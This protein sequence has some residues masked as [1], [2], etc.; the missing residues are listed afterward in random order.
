MCGWIPGKRQNMAVWVFLNSNL[1]E[2]PPWSPRGVVEDAIGIEPLDAF[3]HRSHTT[4][5]AAVSLPRLGKSCAVP[6][7]P[8][9]TLTSSKAT[10]S[11]VILIPNEMRHSV[12]I[13]SISTERRFARATCKARK[14]SRSE[15]PA[16]RWRTNPIL[17]LRPKLLLSTVLCNSALVMCITVATVMHVVYNLFSRVLKHGSWSRQANFAAVL[18]LSAQRL[19]GGSGLV[20]LGN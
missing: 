14:H 20:W 11:A 16:R 8:T 5:Y 7:G 15:R 13:P 6:S 2:A 19:A 3:D 17:V 1:F 4:R 9:N 18:V 12:R 10:M